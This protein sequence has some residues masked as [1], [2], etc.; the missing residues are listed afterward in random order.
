[1]LLHWLWL[2]GT[3]PLTIW[4]ISLIIYRLLKLMLWKDP[5]ISNRQSEIKFLKR[6]SA[7]NVLQRHTHIPP[8]W[9]PH[10]YTHTRTLTVWLSPLLTAFQIIC[11]DAAPATWNHLP[12]PRCS[13]SPLC[14]NNCQREWKWHVYPCLCLFRCHSEHAHRAGAIRKAC[15]C[16]Q[17]PEDIRYRGGLNANWLS[18]SRYGCFTSTTKHK[19]III[20]LIYV[21]L[22][23]RTMPMRSI[24]LIDWV[25]CCCHQVWT[26]GESTTSDLWINCTTS[27]CIPASTGG[28]IPASLIFCCLPLNCLLTIQWLGNLL[29]IYM[30]L[31]SLWSSV[32]NLLYF[33]N[34]SFT[35]PMV[36]VCHSYSGTVV[37]SRAEN[38]AVLFWSASW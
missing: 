22:R 17:Y 36:W 18:W 35:Y 34:P 5:V 23:N 9:H 28:Q 19:I 13:G 25:V 30:L 4:R 37:P 2:K 38:V 1:M 20:Q 29:G 31:C 27:G 8:I 10:K 7:L 33:K 11:K 24:S 14:V 15:M 3:I 12:A 6:L 21:C 16:T 32:L 26:T